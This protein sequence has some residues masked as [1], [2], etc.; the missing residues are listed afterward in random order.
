M[1]FKKRLPFIGEIFYNLLYR[2]IW[3][4][5][6]IANHKLTSVNKKKIVNL[7]FFHVKQGI[8]C[9]YTFAITG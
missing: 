1:F 5:M 9:R 6:E 2:I 7:N 8:T 4:Y 3:Y